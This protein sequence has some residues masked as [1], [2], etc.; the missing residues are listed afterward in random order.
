MHVLR[1]M[2]KRPNFQF[3]FM[4]AKNLTKSPWFSSRDGHAKT[5]PARR[6]L[7]TVMDIGRNRNAQL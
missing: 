2:W 4:T 6:Y 1:I 3:T 5:K 7:S